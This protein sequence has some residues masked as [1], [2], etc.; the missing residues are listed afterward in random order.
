[1]NIRFWWNSFIEV[2]YKDLTLICDPWVNEIKRG[3]GWLPDMVYDLKKVHDKLQSC[4][5]IYISHIHY[6]HLDIQLLKS[7]KLKKEIQFIIPKLKNKH[8]L[9][10]LKSLGEFRIIELEPY[11]SLIIENHLRIILVPQLNTNSDPSNIGIDYDMDSS[12]IIINNDDGSSFFNMVDNPLSSKNITT[13]KKKLNLKSFDLSTL[14]CGSAS[15]YPQSFLGI[16][17]EAE[18][19]KMTTLIYKRCKEKLMTLKSKY[20]VKAGGEYLIGKKYKKLEKFKVSLNQELMNKLS[21]ESNSEYIKTNSDSII[22]LKAGEVKTKKIDVL[23]KSSLINLE[24][25][26]KKNIYLLENNV[27]NKSINKLLVKAK[28]NLDKF[29]KN[30]IKDIGYDL[31]CKITIHSYEKYPK[32]S[33]EDPFLIIDNI[34]KKSFN[35]IDPGINTKRKLELHIPNN[36]LEDCIL[37]KHS[38]NTALTSS[39]ILVDRNP[40]IFNPKDEQIL[41]FATC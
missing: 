38:W 40:N 10:K 7:V 30:H 22:E 32:V 14:V 34:N 4:D 28:F 17:R 12:L 33:K 1:M 15:Q 2:E 6:D 21:S 27:S 25:D 5:Y 23:E 9:K 18:Q 16:N 11:S 36:I 8:L 20:F 39:V 35:L 26:N 19:I 41:N 24:N 13:I 31:A 37:K 3:Y 29:L